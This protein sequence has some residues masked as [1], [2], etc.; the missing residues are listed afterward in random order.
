MTVPQTNEQSQPTSQALHQYPG[1]SF[2][3]LMTEQLPVYHH[4]SDPV[5]VVRL[6]RIEGA[7]SRLQETVNLL[8]ERQGQLEVESGQD[9]AES[10]DEVELPLDFVRQPRNSR[11]KVRNPTK[12]DVEG[13]I[14]ALVNG[15]VEEQQRKMAGIDKHLDTVIERMKVTVPE[16]MWPAS[17]TLQTESCCET[18]MKMFLDSVSKSHP[19]VPL[20][21]CEKNWIAHHLLVQKWNNFHG[22][23]ESTVTT[24][25]SQQR[26]EVTGSVGGAMSIC[27]S[28]QS[29]EIVRQF[30][31]PDTSATGSRP[32]AAFPA[33]LTREVS[34][35]SVG[36]DNA[37]ANSRRSTTTTTML[38]N[39]FES[40]IEDY[41]DVNLRHYLVKFW[42]QKFPNDS[43][44][45]DDITDNIIVGQR[46]Y[47]N[48]TVYDAI[49]TK[50]KTEKL[51]HFVKMD[52]E[53]DTKK[54]RRNA[55]ADLQV[56][57]F[58]G[59]V[60]MYFV[61]EYNDIFNGV[62]L[63]SAGCPC[64][65]YTIGHTGG[66]HYVV[67]VE[68]IRSHAGILSMPLTTSSITDNVTHRN[69]YIYPKM[70]PKTIVVGDVGL[71]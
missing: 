5:I 30:S 33:A 45:Y 3:Q 22:D 43:I 9:R 35:H 26:D 14:L 51:C 32:A 16:N 2:A 27:S 65:P 56:Q 54:A 69:Y 53:V 19:F 50:R 66:K 41:A 1:A 59:E 60:I 36:T 34:M 67:E 40:S 13:A 24:N 47:M 11:G 46:L 10:D 21:E 29:R 70:V 57:T 23:E 17:W 49:K 37:S 12:P 6:D 28:L 18:A 39:H 38:W 68:A 55:P 62:D 64:G 48:E 8:V 71:L 63:N 20:D 4:V 52:I 15:N 44:G 42:R 25:D 58:F 7:I 61:H 31:V